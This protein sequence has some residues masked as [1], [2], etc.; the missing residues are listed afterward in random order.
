MDLKEKTYVASR[1][2]EKRIQWT[3]DFVQKELKPGSK[4]LDLGVPNPVSK[5][6]KGHGF[7]V[8]S[9]SSSDLDFDC[10]CVKQEGFDAFTSFEVFEHMLNP[11]TLLSNI[12]A[13]RLITSVPLSLWFAKAY[14]G[15]LSEDRFDEHYHEFEPWQFESLLAKAGWT[16][17]RTEFHRSYKSFSFGVRPILRRF[18]YRYMMVSAHRT[19]TTT[20]KL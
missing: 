7:H 9:A 19:G 2:L 20:T 3:S 18:H 4:I 1:A 11:L 17:D 12:Q 10:E 6:L 8:E 5:A 13:P 14:R 16:I 15:N